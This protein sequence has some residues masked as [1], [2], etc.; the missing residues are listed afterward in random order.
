MISPNTDSSL[1]LQFIYINNP[2]KI[3]T[4]KIKGEVIWYGL[5]L[6]VVS[7]LTDDSDLG[8]S[9]LR[10]LFTV[11]RCFVK[12]SPWLDASR[13]YLLKFYDFLYFS[14]KSPKH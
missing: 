2:F 9:Q 6:L 8:S 13:V 12:L 7:L 10:K 1:R 14:T 4:H 3:H 11:A 5:F